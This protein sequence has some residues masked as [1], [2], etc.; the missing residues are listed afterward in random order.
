V[1]ILEVN[2]SLFRVPDI[3][4]DEASGFAYIPIKD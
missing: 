2:T 4:V 1:K 3:E